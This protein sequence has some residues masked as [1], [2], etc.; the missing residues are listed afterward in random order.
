VPSAYFLTDVFVELDRQLDKK[1]F[2]P[3]KGECRMQLAAQEGCK[4]KKCLGA[5]RALWRSSRRGGTDKVRHLKSFLRESPAHHGRRRKRS[6]SSDGDNDNEAPAIPDEAAEHLPARAPRDEAASDPTSEEE[7]K[8]VCDEAASDPT[9]EEEKELAHD[10]S[11]EEKELARDEAASDPASEE[12]GELVRDEAASDPESEEEQLP[13]PG[14]VVG[15]GPTSHEEAAKADSSQTSCSSRSDD[16]KS[17]D[18]LTAPTLILG[19]Q[20]EES[21]ESGSASGSD[22]RD[23]QVSSG[24][25]GKAINYYSRKENEVAHI[26]KLLKDIKADLEEAMGGV[27][28]EAGQWRLY[29]EWCSKALRTYGD[30][31]YSKLS[32]LESFKERKR[33]FDK[34]MGLM[35]MEHLDDSESSTRT[36]AAKR[37]A[38]HMAERKGQDK[39]D[40]LGGEQFGDVLN[41]FHEH[42]LDALQVL[43]ILSCNIFLGGLGIVAQLVRL[44]EIQAKM[45]FQD[46]S[47]QSEERPLPRNMKDKHRCWLIAGLKHLQMPLVQGIDWSEQLDHFESFSGD[48]EVTKAEWEAGRS[49]APFDVRLD[50]ERMDLL[51][52]AG[53][54]NAL[55]CVCRLK[56]SQAV[57]DGNIL[58]ARALILVILAA[59]KACFWVLEQPGSSIMHLHPLFQ[60]CIRR[61]GVERL[62]IAMGNYGA[63]TPKRTILFTGHGR[64][65]RD[66][67]DYAQEP[68]YEQREMVVS[69]QNQKGERRVHGGKTAKA[70]E[71]GKEKDAKRK[72]EVQEEK[73][74]KKGEPKVEDRK[75]KKE[76]KAEEPEKK[77]KTAQKEESGKEKKKKEAKSEP[78]E[79]KGAKTSAEE[80]KKEKGKK[81]SGEVKKEDKT[82]KKP[83]CKEGKPH[84]MVVVVEEKKKSGGNKNDKEEKD[85]AGEGKKKDKEGKK[86]K[87]EKKEKKREK[88]KDKK[89]DKDTVKRKRKG[90]EGEMPDPKK[91]KRSGKTV[92]W[93]PAMKDKIEPIFDAASTKSSSTSLS[94]K[95]KAEKRLA[96][97]AAVLEASND[98]DSESCNATDLEAFVD[99]MDGSIS[100]DESMSCAEESDE[101]EQEEPEEEE[102]EE[103]EDD[104]GGKEED[105]EGASESEEESADDKDQEESDEDESEEEGEEEDEGD[106][107]GEEKDKK[108]PEEPCHAL[109]PIAQHTAETAVALRNSMTNKREW[110]TFC[111]QAKSK[112]KMPVE[113][114]DMFVSQKT[115]L[116]NL[117]LDSNYSWKECA[118]AVERQRREVAESK[119]G[120]KAVQGKELKKQYTP[121]KWQ[122]LR[123]KRIQ[124]GLVYKDDDFGSDEEETGFFRCSRAEMWYFVRQ[125]DEI[126]Q[127]EQC[128]ETLGMK[129]KV[130]VDPDMRSAL[131]SEDGLLRP[132]ALPKVAG[133]SAGGSK[134]LLQAI[135]TGVAAPKKKKK[136]EQEQAQE[137]EPQTWAEKAQTLLPDMLKEACEARKLSIKLGGLEFA[138]ELSKDL[139][140]HAG[141][142]EQSYKKLAAKVGEGNEKALKAYVNSANDLIPKGSKAQVRQAVRQTIARLTAWSMKLASSGVGP[143]T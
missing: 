36:P 131:T 142:L 138:Q 78:Q 34:A 77:E 70:K 140:S 84:K 135:T 116:F 60:Y 15:T 6:A 30:S 141:Q 103:G 3:V 69:Y 112:G 20:D 130:D 23:S 110:D 113:L 24:W 67:H 50:P 115:E 126:T 58:T 80:D 8:L 41:K 37:P 26:Q 76:K 74:E 53:F 101:S 98:S 127:K 27:L 49:A 13:D 10:E 143:D 1:M 139:L 33:P 31:A 128:I 35:G 85:V 68:E 124:Q 21:E 52:P 97:L 118:L 111:R 56:D 79:R 136:E 105:E 125:G 62:M 51:S 17:D 64:C 119:R 96:E 5:L 89:K 65:L 95:E 39:L 86:G 129:A 47:D 7:G 91:S 14:V 61:I 134:V 25:M 4:L 121:E 81:R 57:R 72:V 43:Q 92:K 55:H 108:E 88:S 2:R 38:K 45:P 102:D 106:V 122:K 117:W 46:D 120:W 44:K 94:S 82:A 66:I 28:L 87:K 99:N 71:M 114:S 40:E 133:A 18:S 83:E 75:N 73:K 9:S 107:K 90:K 32:S 100:G 12:E 123:D 132:G 137:V 63:P 29:E 16:E 22:H 11:E 54:A 48:A 19:Q 109:V 93:Q 104:E 59:C 42:D